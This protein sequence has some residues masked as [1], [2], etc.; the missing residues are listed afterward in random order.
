MR[1]HLGCIGAV[2]L[3]DLSEETQRCLERVQA[4]WLEF[5]P[6]PPSVVVRHVQPDDVPALRKITGELLEF[7]SDIPEAERSRIPG[8]CLYYLDE[9]NGQYV[10]LRVG[11]GG[12]LTVAWARPDYSHAQWQPYLGQAVSLVFESYQRLN[13]SVRFEATSTGLDEIRAELERPGGL[14][15]QGDCEIIS[16]GNRTEIFFRDV[17]ASVLA[18]L[19]AL[20][21]AAKQGSLEGEIDVSSFRAGDVEDYCRFA[22]KAG[23][24][25]LL[26]PSLWND[27]PTTRTP[28]EQP[29]ERA[30]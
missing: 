17:N 2:E 27:A 28:P 30:A 5:S 3:G 19:E 16:S 18:M 1:T 7:L 20:R 14:Y 29:F 23:E 8:G 10:R 15:P 22:V 4:T 13:G 11:K 9:Q 12:L 24:V 21:G 26:R 6:D 25:W